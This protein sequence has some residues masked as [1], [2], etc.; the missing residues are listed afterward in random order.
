MNRE[1]PKLK[2]CISIPEILEIQ[3]WL[4]IF[5]LGTENSTAHTCQDVQPGA[6]YHIA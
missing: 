5:L 3:Y 4:G 6:Q 2:F 1:F